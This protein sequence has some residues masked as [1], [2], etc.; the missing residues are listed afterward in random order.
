MF[1]SNCYFLCIQ[2][3]TAKTLP[4]VTIQ[5]L[6]MLTYLQLNSFHLLISTVAI[7]GTLEYKSHHWHFQ[8]TFGIFFLF[9]QTTKRHL[10]TEHF[11]YYMYIYSLVISKF[12]FDLVGHI[13]ETVPCFSM[14]CHVPYSCFLWQ[15]ATAKDPC[16]FVYMFLSSFS[17]W[18]HSLYGCLHS[19]A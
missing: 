14:H 9:M 19:N 13:G 3:T 5:I 7:R 15:F 1:Y 17:A 18:F 4:K 11:T 16:G 8:F 2:H 6:T 10:V 12:V